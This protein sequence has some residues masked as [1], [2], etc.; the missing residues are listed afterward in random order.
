MQLGK[1]NIQSAESTEQNYTLDGAYVHDM[2]DVAVLRVNTRIDMNDNV[3]R[4]AMN[5][6]KHVNVGDDITIAGWGVYNAS[7]VHCSFFFSNKKIYK[8][9]VV[10]TD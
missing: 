7:K 10:T 2:I 3:K 1:H 6:D 4:L 5:M 9:G 8:K